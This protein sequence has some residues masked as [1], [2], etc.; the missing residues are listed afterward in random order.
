[1]PFGINIESVSNRRAEIEEA[2]SL[3]R[4]LRQHLHR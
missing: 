3:A 2:V 4:R 1:M